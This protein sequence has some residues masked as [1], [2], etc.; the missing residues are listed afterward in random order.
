MSLWNKIIAIRQER[1]VKKIF[2]KAE[3]NRERIY[4]PLGRLSLAVITASHNSFCEISPLIKFESTQER[5]QKQFPISCE[6]VY[7][8]SHLALRLAINSGFTPDHLQKICAYHYPLLA[9][10]TVDSFCS[11]W[12]QEIKDKLASQFLEHLHHANA[13]Y[14][15]CLLEPISNDLFHP[16]FLLA[17]LAG[18][19]AELCGRPEDRQFKLETIRVAVEAR[20]H[21][22]L[23]PIF[24]DMAGVIDSATTDAFPLIWTRREGLK[25]AS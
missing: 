23:L 10:T 16:R 8:F 12:P 7:C 19:I 14:A 21:M 4:G 24:S 2:R 9:T 25:K 20:E 15:D 17:R 11:H 13:E 5:D 22:D 3:A 18:C 6:L 1:Q